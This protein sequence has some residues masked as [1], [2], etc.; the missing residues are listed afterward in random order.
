MRTGCHPQARIFQSNSPGG[1]TFQLFR[2]LAPLAFS[3]V[4]P[5]WGA[6][7]TPSGSALQWQIYASCAAAYQT[8]WQLR[9]SSRSQDMSNM[10]QEQAEDYKAKA[11][12]FYEDELRA[13]PS[14]AHRIV[15]TYVS[16]NLDRFAAMEKAGTLEAYIDQCPAN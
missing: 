4:S 2:I 6:A 16:S 10:I 3:T 12:K 15:E 7:Q 5:S 11:A 1:I 13:Q 9:Q 8:N 14:E